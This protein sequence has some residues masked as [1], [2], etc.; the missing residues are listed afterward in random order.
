MSTPESQSNSKPH[1]VLRPET[2]ALHEGWHP[3]APGEP[4]AATWYPSTVFRHP[5]QGLSADEWS[6]TRLDNPNR[7]RLE[8]TL[9]SLEGGDHALAFS[10]GMA[11][12]QAAL[13]ILDP[14]D[15]VLLPDDLYHG[16]RNLI[17]DQYAR[18][19]LAFDFVDMT[20]PEAVEAAATARTRMLWLET[21]SNPMLR[22]SDIRKL[23]GLAS[24]RGWISVVDNTWCTP[25][26][27][28]P[29]ELG[30]DMVLYSTT[31]YLGGH[32]DVLGGALVLRGGGH[33]REHFGRL[34][35]VQRQAGAVPSPFDCWL[36]LR[37]LKTLYVRVRTQCSGAAHIAGKLAAHP[38]VGKVHYPG[39]PGHSGREIA[40]GQ[41]DLPGAMISFEV[42]GDD[43]AA[44][45]VVSSS[46]IIIPATSLG[47][48]ETTWEHR[49][50]S[51][52]EGTA[53]PGNL[54]RLSIGLEH[55][56]DIWLDIDQ[57]LAASG[58]AGNTEALR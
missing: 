49:K 27:Q 52:Y 29:L 15:H 5:E 48:V 16:V 1:K 31:K 46:R 42:K 39:L 22:I 2:R 54:I 7:S 43:A 18:W 45:R 53:T 14:G 41:M 6:Y 9:A 40:D 13:H 28:R 34:Q 36:M 57:A 11:A 23:A 21:P 47:G 8:A 24:E 44:L 3:E 32:S 38:A 30:A 56:D 10:S 26:I 55:P 12:V 51:E 19:G 17:R 25:V 33:M 37:S 58:E 35:S 50:T 4:V 20:R